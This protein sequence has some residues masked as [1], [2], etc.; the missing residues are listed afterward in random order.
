MASFTQR[1]MTSQSG[2]AVAYDHGAQVASWSVEGVPVVWVSGRSEYAHGKAIRGGVPICWPWFA[3]GPDGNR[4][5]SHGL[6][7]TVPWSI[8]EV[9]DARLTWT[10]SDRNLASASRAAFPYPFQCRYEA[11]L[12][13]RSLELRLSVT[14]PGPD[15]WSYELALHTYLHVGD[16]RAITITGL[17]G[18]SYYD[19]VAGLDETQQGDLRIDDEIDRIYDRANP[20]RVLDPT[21]G[22]TIDISSTGAGNTVIWNPGPE[23]ALAMSDFGDAEWTQMV[24]VETANIASNAVRLEPGASHTTT[25]RIGVGHHDSTGE[26]RV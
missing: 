15:A 19:K 13:E 24:C 7:R 2:A 20:L 25:T 9:D 6:V 17:G 3:S 10:L 21:L 23:T 12:S 22:R 4:Q 1:T 26:S 8:E 16:V 14:N 5:P 11:L 18:A